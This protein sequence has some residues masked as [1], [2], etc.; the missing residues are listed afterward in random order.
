MKI[1][2][3]KLAGPMKTGFSLLLL[4]IF[5]SLLVYACA[6]PGH[7]SGGNYD[8]EPPKF[9]RSTPGPNATR[10]TGN[11]VEL[12]FD[13]YITLEKPND[14]VIVTPPQ[15]QSPIIKGVGRKVSVELKDSLIL[16]VTYTF[17]FTNSIADNN[18][19]NVLEGF[20]F[21]FS[22]GDVIDTMMISG[23]LLNAQNLEPMP[24]TLVGLH[25]NLADSAFTTIPFNRTS[26][27][28]ETGHFRIRNIAPGEYHL[29]ALED[30]NRN[31][32]YDYPAEG[33][34]FEDSLIIPSFIPDVRMDTIWRDSLTVDTIR[35]IHYN[36]FLPDNIVLYYFTDNFT[37][38][39]F[40]KAERS[41][42]RQFILKFNSDAG[43]PPKPYLFEGESPKGRDTI[44]WYIREYSPDKKD[45]I[46]WITDSLIYKRDT[47]RIELDYLAHDS[48]NNLIPLTDTLQLNL[49]KQQAPKKKEK[50]KDK[51]PQ[52]DFLEIKMTPTGT[53]DVFDTIKITF[54]EP[55]WN[56]DPK[57]LRIQQKVDTIWTN[58]EFPIIQDTLNPRMYYIEN[59]WNYGQEFRLT[60][61]SAEIY[62]VYEKWNDSIQFKWSIQKMEEYGDLYVKVSGNEYDGFG[63]L[64]NSSDKVVRSSFLYDGELIFENLKPGKY[65]LRYIDDINGNGKWD[66]GNYAEKRQP[67]K[68]YYFEGVFETRK[69]LEIEHSWDI[70]AIPRT[71][72][73]P[74]EITKNKPKEKKP[75]RSEQQNNQRNNSGTNS[76]GGNSSGGFPGGGISRRTTSGIQPI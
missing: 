47:I 19:R 57:K 30:V 28:S 15:M 18:E 71:K 37:P 69:L 21:A 65:Y 66:P 54:G 61:D 42:D 39:Y 9:L 7:P 68:V 11:K 64:L 41:S 56:L 3:N 10:F 46:F 75:K 17:D 72:Q 31:Y 62:S 36:R 27:T 13:E 16:D 43:F 58:R 29:F 74:L 4:F 50:E 23:L 48:L 33:I 52:I 5:F 53:V 73:K 59:Q 40:S 70:K 12:F 6:S 45:V 60:I 2:F 22:T 44:P 24:A 1:T 26:R 67:E 63:E 49:R 25:R 8:E 51:K 38:Q 76:N 34:A 32:K 55:L 14:N 35:E 20:T